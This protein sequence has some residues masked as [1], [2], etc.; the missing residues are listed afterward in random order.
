MFEAR[1]SVLKF[2]LKH[3]ELDIPFYKD[4]RN[5]SSLSKLW[6]GLMEIVKWNLSFDRLIQLILIISV[7]IATMDV[8]F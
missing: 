5:L 3:Y 7:L 2:Q 8:Y 4:F 1:E 6:G